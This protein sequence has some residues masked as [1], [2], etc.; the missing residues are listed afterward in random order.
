MCISK[1]ICCLQYVKYTVCT[2]KVIDGVY[3]LGKLEA[4]S[5]NGIFSKGRNEGILIFTDLEL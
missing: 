2:L 4:I 3:V 5:K 1:V